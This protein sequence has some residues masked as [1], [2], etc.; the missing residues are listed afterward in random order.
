MQRFGNPFL[1]LGAPLLI[2]VAI[3]GLLQRDGSD[4]LQSLPAVLAGV[5]LIISGA[6][7]RRNRRKRL[8][9]AMRK[10]N[11]DED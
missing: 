4:R 1:S 10:T 11:Q 3:M 8:L 9:L 6:I 7:E 5:G 2:L